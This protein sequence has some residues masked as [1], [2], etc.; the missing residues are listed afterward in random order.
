MFLGCDRGNMNMHYAYINIRLSDSYKHPL[1]FGRWKE[2]F[3]LGRH[4]MFIFMSDTNVHFIKKRSKDKT[5]CFSLHNNN[6]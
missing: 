3:N 4:S 1:Y 5:I 2:C 6:K